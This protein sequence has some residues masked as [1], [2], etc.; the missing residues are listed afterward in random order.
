VIDYYCFAADSSSGEVGW[1]GGDY[2]SESTERGVEAREKQDVEHAKTI[3]K[4][5]FFD[6]DDGRLY[7]D[8]GCSIQVPDLEGKRI[9]PRAFDFCYEY[10]LKEIEDLGGTSIVSVEG[11]NIVEHWPNHI[12][13]RYRDV[14]IST[15]D[16]SV[17]EIQG[18]LGAKRPIFVKTVAKDLAGVLRGVDVY[19]NSP[20]GILTGGGRKISIL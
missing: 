8:E 5:L 11:D 1:F 20:F 18:A 9:F 10:M 12:Q 7:F 13:P 6:V 19:G 14:K 4:A 17:G 15:M 16:D 3:G 2:F